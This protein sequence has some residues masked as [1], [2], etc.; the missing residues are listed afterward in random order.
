MHDYPGTVNTPLIS[1]KKGIIGILVRAYVWLFG[2]W[3]CMPV[4]ESG[5]RHLYLATSARFKAESGGDADGVR[6]AGLD[7]VA[8]GSNGEIWSGI[9]AVG[10]TCEGGSEASLKLLAMYRER[11]LADNILRHAE[12][13]FK[14]ITGVGETRK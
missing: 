6:V 10:S 11:G 13:E 8:K 4:E 1:E 7:S 12:S 14:R 3:V 5:E 2:R 9:Y